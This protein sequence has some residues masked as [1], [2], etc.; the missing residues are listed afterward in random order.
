MILFNIN[1]HGHKLSSIININ[2][3]SNIKC[4]K[5]YRVMGDKANEKAVGVSVGKV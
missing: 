4:M 2:I 5:H 3:L 1:S